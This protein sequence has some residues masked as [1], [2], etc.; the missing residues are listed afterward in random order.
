MFSSKPGFICGGSKGLLWSRLKLKFCQVGLL[1][2]TLDE[3][4]AILARMEKLVA[5]ICLTKARTSPSRF[6][7]TNIASD[8]F[9]GGA[10]RAAKKSC[11]MR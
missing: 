1:L 8:Q 6:F 5:E 7:Q 4:P 2:F 9:A 10:D 3:R 11:S